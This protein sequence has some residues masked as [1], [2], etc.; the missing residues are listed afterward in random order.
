VGFA[1]HDTFVVMDNLQL[2]GINVSN[3][4]PRWSLPISE[5]IT[6]AAIDAASA[7]VYTG[8]QLGHVQAFGLSDLVSATQKSVPAPL[9]EIQL[10]AFGLPTLIPLPGGG[11]AL[12]L[13]QHLFG[14]SANGG[15][16][17]ELDSMDDPTDWT[18]AQDRL[19]LTSAGAD[20]SVWVIDRARPPVQ[21]VRIG[22]RLVS[23]GDQVFVYN[24]TGIYHLSPNL[25]SAYLLYPLPR[26]FPDLGDAVALPGGGLLVAH[27]DQ[28]DGR[29]IA[30]NGDGTL[31]WQRSYVPALRAQ[32]ATQAQ[33]R[34][35]VAGSQVYLLLHNG[36][37]S[38]SITDIFSID[39]DSAA[40]TRIFTGGTRNLAQQDLWAL[41]VDGDHLLVN[42]GGSN[43]T[44]LDARLALE[45]VQAVD[46]SE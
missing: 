46:G 11:V 30:L 42:Y 34:L 17:W 31:R 38:A 37:S 24:S 12:H 19:I 14:V 33:P 15:L 2:M 4:S 18:L 13:Y 44:A 21:A 43:V 22:G 35:V 23:T 1:G 32:S 45:T 7:I 41:A 36:T 9:W 6:A 3:G 5:T 16:L 8:D 26:A 10:D 39:T 28:A 20:A 40:L 27:V 25:L 29:L